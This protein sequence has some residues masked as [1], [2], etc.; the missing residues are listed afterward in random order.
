MSRFIDDVATMER[1]DNN[2][3]FINLTDKA[4]AYA[5]Y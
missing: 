4:R 2:P 5:T 3:D 1:Q